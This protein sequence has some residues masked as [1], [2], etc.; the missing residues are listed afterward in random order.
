MSKRLTALFLALIMIL[1]ACRAENADPVQGSS[2]VGEPS[3]PQEER[4]PDFP[5]TVAGV[6]IQSKPEKIAALNPS[7]VEI[8]YDMGLGDALCGVGEA[9]GQAQDMPNMGMPMLGSE[10][11]P[12]ITAILDSGAQLVLTASPIPQAA[13]QA[14]SK[15]GIPLIRFEKPREVPLLPGYY[16]DIAR[17]VLGEQ[18]GRQRAQEFSQPLMEQYGRIRALSDA[19][20][21]KPLGAFA[22]FL[23]LTLATGDSM[24]GSLLE[25]CGIEN[26]AADYTG[27]QYPQELLLPFNPQIL[28]VDS[29]TVKADEVRAHPNYKTTPCVAQGKIL[30][31][32]GSALENC[33][34]RLFESMA[35]MALFAHSGWPLG[36]DAADAGAPDADTSG[37]EDAKDESAQ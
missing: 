19:A 36:Q 33:G 26:A 37:G 18:A 14:L 20:Q 25:V 27:W 3:E 22:A 32:D 11:A 4:D 8:L 24:Q 23:P 29:R 28:V 12:D 21:E 2:A 6:E 16:E 5:A 1:C 9:C 13:V 17:A 30:E 15:A 7:I 31:I 35:R 10:I 34:A